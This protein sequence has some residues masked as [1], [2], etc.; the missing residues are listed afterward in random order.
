[1]TAYSMHLDQ[2]FQ[3]ETVAE[4]HIQARNLF[5]TYMMGEMEVRAVRNVSL[6]LDRG[7]FTA[8][9]GTSGSGKTSLLNLLGCLDRPSS[10]EIV[11]A[12]KTISSM[13]DNELAHFRAQRLGFIF[14]NFNLMPVLTA[15]ENVEYA[16]MKSPCSAKERTE[17]AKNALSLV[18]LDHVFRHRPDQLSGGQRQRVAIARAIVHSPELIIA[19][20]PT[21]NL[22]QKTAG[23]ILD[24]I[25]DLN[26]KM[27]VTILIATH[28]PMV[29]SRAQRVVHMIDGR[30]K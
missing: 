24:L 11:I 10:G 8:L 19:D 16:L 21:A 13:N 28:D 20:E 3:A 15:L 14:Q 6:T 9:C 30:I 17:K 7:E 23:E 26:W 27:G 12:G 18:G 29:M 22:D 1:M 5:M 25:G 2:K 4:T